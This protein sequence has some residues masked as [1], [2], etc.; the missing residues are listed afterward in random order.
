MHMQY[1]QAFYQYKKI[2]KSVDIRDRFDELTRIAHR[3]RSSHHQRN[4][5]KAQYVSREKKNRM[6]KSMK[7]VRFSSVPGNMVMAAGG[8]GDYEGGSAIYSAN[9]HCGQELHIVGLTGWR[10]AL[11]V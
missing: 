9:V 4:Q 3:G 5:S 1:F 2:G 8:Q 7:E 10:C 11:G 6:R